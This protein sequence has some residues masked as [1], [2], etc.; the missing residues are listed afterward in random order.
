[1]RRGSTP[2]ERRRLLDAAISE[3]RK[4][5]D[6]HRASTPAPSAGTLRTLDDGGESLSQTIDRIKRQN[7][8][9]DWD[10]LDGRSG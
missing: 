10:A 2:S 8:H 1:M 6:Q 4:H 9:I 5:L 3:G 7:S